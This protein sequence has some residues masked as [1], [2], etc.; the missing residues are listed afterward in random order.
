MNKAKKIISLLVCTAMML[1]VCLVS[2]GRADAK[3]KGGKLIKSVTVYRYNEKEKKIGKEVKKYQYN[4]KGDLV[5]LTEKSSDKNIHKYVC[6][7]KHKYKK[8]KKVFTKGYY[9]KKLAMKF[10]FDK[11]GLIKK[12]MVTDL[13][14]YFMY[15][16]NKK[17]YYKKQIHVSKSGKMPKVVSTYSGYKYYGNGLPK[18]VTIKI[19]ADK[20]Y[21]VTNKYK[22]NK[23]GLVVYS[24][25][26]GE[27]AKYQ[28]KYNKNGTV[29]VINELRYE[30]AL[31]KFVKHRTYVIKYANK[32]ISAKGYASMINSNM[33]LS[34]DSALRNWR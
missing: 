2:P 21:T 14:A 7:Y 11:K 29:K 23:K 1:T 30:K 5:K 20:Y 31:K 8:G 24:V 12:L 32:N 9:N 26:K 19:S 22:Y 4:K 3:A 28:Y 17:G 34:G 10:M 27:I 25:L 15:K 6:T 16:Y 18:E 13:N 33:S